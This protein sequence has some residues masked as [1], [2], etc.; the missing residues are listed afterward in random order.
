[1][2]AGDGASQ[3]A[4]DAFHVTDESEGILLKGVV[5]RKKQLIPNLINALSEQ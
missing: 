3:L 1:V 2:C 5:S 4:S